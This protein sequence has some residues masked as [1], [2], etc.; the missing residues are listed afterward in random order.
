MA[1]GERTRWRLRRPASGRLAVAEA[2]PTLPLR[3]IG[4]LDQVKLSAN[5]MAAAGHPGEDAAS[6]RHRESWS[7][8]CQS[9][10]VSI[11]VGKDSLSMKTGVGR[12]RRKTQRHL[13]AVA[14]HL[15]V[16]PVDDVTPHASPPTAHRHCRN[17]LACIGSGQRQA[18][19]GGS[20]LAQVF[21]PAAK[22]RIWWTAKSSKVSPCAILER[23]RSG[24]GLSRPLGRRPVRHAGG[25][26]LP[27][28]PAWWS[29]WIAGE[30]RGASTA[31]C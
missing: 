22:R 28:A 26:G 29:S 19:L 20:A 5:W 11:P 6:V 10:K 24:A 9:L 15:G 16:C 7:E 12:G 14:D 3:R 21:Q 4:R 30:K 13:A 23:R 31:M 27:A 18:R 17:R 1:M 2:L 25:N 8:L